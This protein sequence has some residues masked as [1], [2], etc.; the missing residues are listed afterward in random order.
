MREFEEVYWCHLY[1]TLEN[2]VPRLFSLW[3]C[4]Q[5]M[6]VAAT[7]ENLAMRDTSGVRYKKCPCCNVCVET[8]EHILYCQ[9]A[10]RVDYLMKSAD[11]LETWLDKSGTNWDLLECIVSYVQGR[12][13]KTMRE[14]CQSLGPR[15]KKLAKSQDMIGWRRF[16]EGMISKEIVSLQKQHLTVNGSEMSLERWATGLVQNC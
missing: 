2:K 14:C 3:A 4:K 10:G 8:A 12:G 15:Y 11:I 9:E 13:A 7:N 6:G 1:E 5:V 16:M